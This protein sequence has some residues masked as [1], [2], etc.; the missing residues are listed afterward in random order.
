MVA[1]GRRAVMNYMAPSKALSKQQIWMRRHCRKPKEMTTKAFYSH[2]IRINSEELPNIP[3]AFDK[4]QCLK[5][6]DL[7]DI[8]LNSIPKRWLVE[9]ERIAFDPTEKNI[10]ELLQQCER[11][12]S[13]DTMTTDPTTKIVEGKSSTKGKSTKKVKTHH[14]KK[15]GD[16]VIHGVGC[17]HSTEECK[18]I[19][20]AK[21]KKSSYN[22]AAGTSST[23]KSSSSKSK[24][25]TKK[26]DDAKTS[27]KKE[28]MAFLE[29]AKEEFRKEL[30]AFKKTEKKKPSPKRKQDES[31]DES[32]ASAKSVNQFETDE[33]LFDD[34]ENIAEGTER[35]TLNDKPDKAT[36]DDESVYTVTSK[37][38][39]DTTPSTN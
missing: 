14:G 3:P 38:D 26:S 28:M 18:I 1:A 17:G 36:K 20:G 33:F 34:D 21:A 22:S 4:S 7:I 25:W 19:I 35:M 16:C 12:E 9:F 8:I 29:V 24:T 39:D 2:L 37:K 11:M 23:Q 10:E 15:T 30:N 6:D 31:D 27:T 32:Y 5:D 13:I